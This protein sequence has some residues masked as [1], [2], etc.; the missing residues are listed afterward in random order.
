M[1]GVAAGDMGTETAE[2][3]AGMPGTDAVEAERGSEE[4]VEAEVAAEQGKLWSLKNR[5][6]PGAEEAAEAPVGLLESGGESSETRPERSG[7]PV[8]GEAAGAA[9]EVGDAAAAAAAGPG[10]GA[11]LPCVCA[12]PACVSVPGEKRLCS[13][14]RSERCPSSR[15]GS[16]SSERPPREPESPAAGSAGAGA[17]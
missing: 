16:C 12:L 13:A 9:A 4:A 3:E 11:G 6:T 14:S 15:R 1:A 2:A 17:G 10:P 5:E 8:G 7:E